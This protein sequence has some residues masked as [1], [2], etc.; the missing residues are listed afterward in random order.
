MPLSL[1][2]SHQ[3][4][5]FLQSITYTKT[6]VTVSFIYNVLEAAA[7]A[8]KN[9]QKERKGKRPTMDNNEHFHF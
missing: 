8:P 6:T 9:T 3:L 4:L 2:I 1:H 5:L 7:V